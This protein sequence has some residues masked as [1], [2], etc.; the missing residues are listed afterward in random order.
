MAFKTAPQELVPVLCTWL[1][2]PFT[3]AQDAAL[4]LLDELSGPCAE[5]YALTGATGVRHSSETS[6]CFVKPVRLQ[7]AVLPRPTPKGTGARL[8]GHSPGTDYA[9]GCP[10]ESRAVLGGRWLLRLT[11]R[12]FSCARVFLPATV[13]AMRQLLTKLMAG[14]ANAL[15]KVWVACPC[16]PIEDCL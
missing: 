16:L 12:N 5:R 7:P 14:P 11:A 15:I 3:E 6:L 13:F 1:E 2:S 4:T 9:A 10:Y 8:C